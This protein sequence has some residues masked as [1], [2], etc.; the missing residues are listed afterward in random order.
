MDPALVLRVLLECLS[1]LFNHDL[2]DGTREEERETEVLHPI[3]SE[4][5]GLSAG[6]LVDEDEGVDSI[7]ETVVGGYTGGHSGGEG[8]FVGEE[9]PVD[10]GKGG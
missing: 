3:G 1:G 8:G 6:N 10:L 4:R 2:A 5:V 7:E 9:S